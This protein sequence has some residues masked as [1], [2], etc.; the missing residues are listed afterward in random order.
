MSRLVNACLEKSEGWES[1]LAEWLESDNHWLERRCR[2]RLGNRLD[3]EDAKQEIAIKLIAS[4]DRFERRSSLKTWVTAIA[5]NHCNTLIRK[6]YAQAISEHL[7]QCIVI[8]E[9]DRQSVRFDLTRADGPEHVQS[10]MQSLSVDN[11]EVLELRFY[12]DLSLSE[13]ATT[14]GLSLSA[15]KMRLYRAIAVFR[16]KYCD[17]R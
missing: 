11:R 1:Q 2:A 9:H 4:F 15:T 10:T 12:N 16:G 14:L 6:R 13:L 8:H 7:A 17:L 3:T 5:D